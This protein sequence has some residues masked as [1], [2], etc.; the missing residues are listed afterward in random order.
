[1]AGSTL[2]REGDKIVCMGMWVVVG[3]I[4]YQNE[5]A[6]EGERDLEFIDSKGQ[7]R[8]WKQ[9]FDGGYVVKDGE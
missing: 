2:I 1:M 3:E 7:Y 6:H 4:I 9:H 8:H 5:Y